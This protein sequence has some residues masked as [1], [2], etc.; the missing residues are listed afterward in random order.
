MA[1]QEQQPLSQTTDTI[2]MSPPTHYAKI[3][4]TAL[5]SNKF[6]IPAEIY[7]D[8]TGLSKQELREVA[9]IEFENM[10]NELRSHDIDVLVLPSQSDVLTNS[11][12][13]NNWFSHH[14]DGTLVVYPMY[15]HERRAERQ[16]DALKGV[17]TQVDITNP[18][19]LDLTEPEKGD[20]ALEGTGSL[21]LDRVNKVAF[22]ME[23]PRTYKDLFDDWCQKMGYEGVF[24]KAYDKKDVPVYHTN[25]VMSVGDGF[26][27]ICAE[28]IK[29]TTEREMVLNKLKETG[30]EVIDISLEQLSDF[31]GNILQV[32]STKGEPKIVMSER[33]HDNFT[34]EQLQ[35]LQKY[36]EIISVF[37]PVIE[38]VGGSARCMM[39]EVFPPTNSDQ[40]S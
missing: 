38:T 7:S 32:T 22:A 14:Q 10:V 39:A 30:H 11:V 31:C 29:D 9:N 6:Y 8:K 25:V 35:T 19:E 36:G 23:S 5:D 12:F 3:V 27:V 21:V 34:P 37:I 1:I 2:V 17:L 16:L 26:T 15:L 28:S 40:L 33:A 20:K 4:S 13:P 18:K 24:F